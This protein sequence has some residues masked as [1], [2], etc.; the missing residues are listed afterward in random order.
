MWVIISEQQRGAVYPAFGM[1]THKLLGNQNKHFAIIFM[2]TA[3]L[4]RFLLSR[5]LFISV[6]EYNMCGGQRST[7]GSFF[8]YLPP[9]FLK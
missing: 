8:R 7:W 5:C 9:C 1:R 4:V 6:H 2:T 3:V